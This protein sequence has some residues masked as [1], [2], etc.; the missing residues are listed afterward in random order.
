MMDRVAAEVVE[1]LDWWWWIFTPA[2]QKFTSVKDINHGPGVGMHNKNSNIKL[3]FV[4]GHHVCTLLN[5]RQ[6]NIFPEGANYWQLWSMWILNMNFKQAVRKHFDQV[7]KSVYC[8]IYL[9]NNNIVLFCVC[10]KF[11]LTVIESYLDIRTASS[12]HSS[13]QMTLRCGYKYCNMKRYS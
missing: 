6:W 10:S 9:L 7:H 4:V 8:I 5:F 12:V 2:A 1:S 3:L 13:K 11:G